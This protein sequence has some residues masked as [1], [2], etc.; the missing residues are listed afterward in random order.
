MVCSIT[1]L[2]H[3]SLL[4]PCRRFRRHPHGDF[5]AQAREHRTCSDQDLR[6]VATILSSEARTLP[7][8]QSSRD[9]D[10]R[11]LDHRSQRDARDENWQNAVSERRRLGLFLS[12]GGRCRLLAELKWRRPSP[13]PQ[14]EF[15]RSWQASCSIRRGSG[16]AEPSGPPRTRTSSPSRT[17]DRGSL[18]YRPTNWPRATAHEACPLSAS[19]RIGPKRRIRR[20]AVCGWFRHCTGIGETPPEWSCR[21]CRI[22]WSISGPSASQLLGRARA[23]SERVRIVLCRA[24]A[25]ST[26]TRQG[27]LVAGGG[28]GS[29]TSIRGSGSPIRRGSRESGL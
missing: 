8:I 22:A 17:G 5:G 19:R 25:G 14:S 11:D 21:P 1:R 24:C 7:W 9:D 6:R 18:D 4:D 13:W 27:S 20:D 16:G 2:N 3:L 15:A 23:A 28:G 29:A 12:G 10:A 26:V